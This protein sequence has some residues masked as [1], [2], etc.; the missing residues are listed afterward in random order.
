VLVG[1]LG[2]LTEV[3]LVPFRARGIGLALLGI[4]GAGKTTV[5][6]QVRASYPLPVRSVHMALWSDEGGGAPHRLLRIGV[7]PFRAVG[8]WSIAFLHRMLGRTVIFDRYVFDAHI[9]PRPPH[10]T[11]KR[12]YQGALARVCP[13][14][15]EV[16][17][18]DLPGSLAAERKPDD[19]DLLEHQ[20][21]DLLAL[22]R[23]LPNLVVVD[24]SLPL[25][26]V[27][28]EVHERLWRRTSGQAQRRR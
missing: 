12:L 7:R 13:S 16:V 8:W 19:P 17:L 27:E 26:L 2:R 10:V 5:A 28:A 18:L 3:L 23:R 1:A 21:L 22:R 14:P 9:S 6:S 15:D 20:R 25:P 24:A 4:D 11:L